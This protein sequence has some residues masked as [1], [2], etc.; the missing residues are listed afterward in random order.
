MVTLTLSVA[1]EQL[2]GRGEDAWVRKTDSPGAALIA[3]LD[4]CGGSGSIRHSR[5][6]DWS[7]ARVSSHQ[8]ARALGRWF[9][10]H[11]N[12][13]RNPN[14]TAPETLAAEMH[15]IFSREL[16]SLKS[17]IT[18]K[19]TETQQYSRLFRQFPTTLAAILVEQAEKNCCRI[20][21][22]WAGDSRTFF[23]P[24]TGLQQTSWDDL[25][26][27]P[28]PFDSLQDGIMSNVICA[29]KP[30]EIHVRETRVEEPCMVLA[31]S[32]GCF[33]YFLTPMHLEAVLLDTLQGATSPKEW[34]ATIGQ[35]LAAVA[36]DDYTLQLA[37]IGF[38]NFDALKAAYA[39]RWQDFCRRYGAITESGLTKELAYTLWLDYKTGYLLPEDQS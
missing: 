39:P 4:G 3:A 33:S 7:S 20:C 34:E 35:V 27:N 21:S 19:E 13:G 8:I 6:G 12:L 29:D 17:Y 5:L 22:F 31:A 23:F 9:D 24:V 25:R 36:G 1:K 18:E 16:E 11:Q 26:G 14:T 10:A 30:F 32:D 28:D 38:S 2:A 15:S 37:V